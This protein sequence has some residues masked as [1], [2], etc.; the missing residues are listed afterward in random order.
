MMIIND[1]RVILTKKENPKGNVHLGG[2]QE[3][4]SSSLH[5]PVSSGV[6]SRPE[7]HW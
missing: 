7:R 6:A 1:K 4:Y 2:L 3:D 5:I